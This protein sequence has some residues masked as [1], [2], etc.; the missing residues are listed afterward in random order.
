MDE[1]GLSRINQL[2]EVSRNW[3]L[4]PKIIINDVT[5]REG[6]Q[7]LTVPFSVEDKVLIAQKL[8]ALGV[9]QIQGGWPARK[10]DD[11]QVI[12]RLKEVGI[13]AQIEAIV[14]V[15]GPNWQEEVDATI[16]C[17]PDVVNLM[18]PTS[19]IRIVEIQGISYADA[20]RRVRD[21]VAH[22]SGRG[23]AIRFGAVDATRADLIFLKD[24]VAQAVEAGADRVG[25][26]DT[27]GA[28]LPTGMAYLVSEILKVVSAPIQVHTHNDL[29]L[30][31]A[32]CLAALEAGATI[33]DVSING[34]G[35]RAGNLSLDE[36]VVVL[37]VLYGQPLDIRTEGLFELSQLVSKMTG[38]RIPPNKPLV[39]ENA[40]VHKLAAHSATARINPKSHEAVGPEVIGRLRHSPS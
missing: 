34:L 7:T 36:L 3:H 20:I 10:A 14:A 24:I 39:G 23:V 28:I 27:V 9:P 35:E 19:D 13:R 31:L 2:D 38:V 40:F 30:A 1:S 25:L 18:H 21:A 22:A 26:A 29:G 17:G 8:D 37:Q 4:A 6:D 16:A 5:L 32:N 15:Y 12:R 11:Q 33:A